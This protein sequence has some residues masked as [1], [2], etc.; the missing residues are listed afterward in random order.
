LQR[1]IRSVLE[2]AAG[3][4]IV[5]RSLAS[6]LPAN[7]ELVVTD[8]N[9][10]MIE[11]AKS[12][13]GQDERIEWR[14]ADAQNLPFENESFDAVACQF[15]AMFFPDKVRAFKESS[16]CAEADWPLLF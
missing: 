5:T 8:L 12:R 7:T 2:V 1:T 9:A 13:I 3:T 4:G 15:G 10:P 11:H 16:S 14:T 6:R